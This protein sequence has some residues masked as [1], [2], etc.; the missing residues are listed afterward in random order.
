MLNMPFINQSVKKTKVRR[1]VLHYYK[2]ALEYN[3]EKNYI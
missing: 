2:M 3:Y 1:Y